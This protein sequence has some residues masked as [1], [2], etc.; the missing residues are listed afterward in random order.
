MKALVL[1]DVQ[2]D[3]MPGGPLAVDDG[4]SIVSVLNRIMTDYD[5]V[6]ATQDWHPS[7]HFSFA[8]QHPGKELFEVI[9]LDGLTQTLW[10]DHCIQ[11]TPGADFH[12]ELN[13]NP[14]EAIFRKGV[15]RQVDS[16]SGFFDNGKRRSTGLD[17]WLRGKGVN[18]VHFGGL[19]AEVCVAFTAEDAAHLGFSAAI[20]EAAIRPLDVNTWN[21]RKLILENAGVSIV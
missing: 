3:F 11:G 14:V 9:E 18:T 7:N 15:E 17:C 5:L 8:S 21:D 1:V 19:A 2:L 20:V 6:A 10:P 4:D 16:Y 12:P 13:M